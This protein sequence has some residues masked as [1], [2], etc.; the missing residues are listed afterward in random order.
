MAVAVSSLQNGYTHFPMAPTLTSKSCKRSSKSS[1][2]WTSTQQCWRITV[3]GSPGQSRR[4][5]AIVRTCHK[6][7]IWPSASLTNGIGLSLASRPTIIASARMTMG[8]RSPLHVKM[9]T[10]A[11][12]G[13]SLMIWGILW[14]KNLSKFRQVEF[15][16]ETKALSCHVQTPLILLKSLHIGSIVSV[17]MITAVAKAQV[18]KKSRKLWTVSRD[19]VSQVLSIAKWRP[20][21][22]IN[23]KTTNYLLKNAWK[24][25]E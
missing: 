16:V 21:S 20:W 11:G 9:I 8:K 23:E 19:R 17:T 14:L 15:T 24:R 4:T 25:R 12:I 3:R 13:T 22:L 18:M 5:R 1:K 2:L 7:R 10:I 6:Y